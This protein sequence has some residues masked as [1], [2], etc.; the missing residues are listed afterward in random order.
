MAKPTT[1]DVIFDLIILIAVG[2]QVYILVDELTDGSFSREMSV[3]Y[4]KTKAKIKDAIE[5]ERIIQRDT[6]K[7][8]FDGITIVEDAANSR[9]D[10]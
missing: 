1:R 8:I 4:T 5:R 6:G 10:G 2:A 7:V 9:D 3:K